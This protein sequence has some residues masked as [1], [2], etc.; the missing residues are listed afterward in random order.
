LE[1]IHRRTCIAANL[2]NKAFSSRS[3]RLY[4]STA[5]MHLHHVTTPNESKQLV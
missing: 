1:V 2:H 5:T 4:T 3:Q